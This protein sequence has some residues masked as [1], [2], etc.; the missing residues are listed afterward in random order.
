MTHRQYRF[1]GISTCY[2]SMP[3]YPN[4]LSQKRITKH[5]MSTLRKCATVVSG[6]SNIREPLPRS[7]QN[8]KRKQTPDWWTGQGWRIGNGT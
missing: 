3:S 4:D 6:H 2:L 1:S 8:A 5:R 7:L